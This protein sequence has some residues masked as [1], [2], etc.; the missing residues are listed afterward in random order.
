[1]SLMVPRV[2]MLTTAGDTRFT[3]GASDGMGAASVAGGGCGTAAGAAGDVDVEGD[4]GDAGDATSA[5]G[6]TSPAASVIAANVRR[7][8]MRNPLY[9][10]HPGQRM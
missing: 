10:G 9:D 5:A 8:L 6:P 1:L 2:A 3:M 4:A 7:K